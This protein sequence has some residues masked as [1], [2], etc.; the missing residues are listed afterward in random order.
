MKHVATLHIRNV[1]DE[2]VAELKQRAKLFGRSLNAE[3]VQV[4]T[5]S[6]PRPKRTL[7]EVLESIRRR[8]SSLPNPPSG[9]E[10]AADIRQA[11][12]ER[13]DEL[14]RAVEGKS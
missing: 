14:M 7:E 8:A 6:M 1:P 5:E 12:E 11:R 4:L 9:D 2:V 10:L 13:A 3:V